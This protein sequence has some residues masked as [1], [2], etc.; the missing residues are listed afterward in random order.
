MVFLAPGCAAGEAP[1]AGAAGDDVLGAATG[2]A[3]DS[4]G[5]GTATAGAGG[6]AGSAGLPMSCRS[7]A[8]ASTYATPT[9]RDSSANASIKALSQRELIS[10]GIPFD[11]FLIFAIASE[12]NGESPP[13]AVFQR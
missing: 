9:L 5:L 3:A 2:A 6:F 1:F 12:S 8:A 10:R 11:H 4:G 7:F 13:P